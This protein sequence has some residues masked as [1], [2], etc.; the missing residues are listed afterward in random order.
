MIKKPP[1]GLT[2]R[3][4]HLEVR[5]FEI[6]NAIRRYRAE[7]EPV[8][9]AWFEELADVSFQLVEQLQRREQDRCQS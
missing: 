8:P 2:R 6:V 5:L 3:D 9:L 7:N 1:I 4:I